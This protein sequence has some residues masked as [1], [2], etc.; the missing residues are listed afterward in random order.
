MRDPSHVKNFCA[1][2][3]VDHGKTTLCDYLI[4]SNG[5][6]SSGL[7]GDL[8]FMDNRA[9]E[10]E[11]HI[12]VKTS[13]ISLAYE[14]SIFNV[15]DSPGHF[16]FTSEVSIALRLC[17]SAFVLIDIVDGVTNQTEYLIRNAFLEGIFM[18]IVFSKIDLLYTVMKLSTRE[19]EELLVRHLAKCNAIMAELMAEEAKNGNDDISN[20]SLVDYFCPSKGNVLFTSSKWGFGFSVRDIAQMYHSKLNWSVQTLEKTLWGPYAFD[21][22]KQRIVKRKASNVTTPSMFEEFILGR[23][24]RIVEA[25][26][27]ANG[28]SG[29][30][31]D[32][33]HDLPCDIQ[34]QSSQISTLSLQ[35][36]LSK[37]SPL[38]SCL[39][40]TIHT[41]FPSAQA[42][43]CA[44]SQKLCNYN[45]SDI[46]D[47]L[48]TDQSDKKTK[49]ALEECDPSSALSIAFIAKVTETFLGAHKTKVAVCKI[50]SG[51]FRV[52]QSVTL[53]SDGK[54][55][56]SGTVD[57]IGLFQGN[58]L[59]SV[60]SI[61]AGNICALNGTF[62]DKVVKFGTLWGQPMHSEI[63]PIRILYPSVFRTVVRPVDLSDRVALGQ[64]LRELNALDLQL[65][66]TI[67]DNGDFVLGTA[68]VVHT[69]RCITDLKEIAQVSVEVSDP[70]IP[71]L[72]T[73]HN[74]PIPAVNTAQE[75]SED[76][77]S[78]DIQVY[79]QPVNTRRTHR[80][81]GT[82]DLT[83][84]FQSFETENREDLKLNI[85]HENFMQVNGKRE[86]LLLIPV[87][88]RKIAASPEWLD[89][90]TSTFHI[91]MKS[92]PLARL[93]VA[94]VC[95]ILR[96]ISRKSTGVS[97]FAQNSL[98]DEDRNVLFKSL[99]KALHQEM[100][101]KVSVLVE[102]CYSCEVSVKGDAYLGKIISLINERRGKIL[103]EEQT[104]HAANALNRFTILATVPVSESQKVIDSIHNV[105]NGHACCQFFSSGW[106]DIADYSVGKGDTNEDNMGQQSVQPK[107]L[108]NTSRALL[109]KMKSSKGLIPRIQ[110]PK[111]AEKQKFANKA[112]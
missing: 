103:S 67:E 57:Y 3:H 54:Q 30:L 78:Y 65:D 64:A 105:S 85:E 100:R 7:A 34:L 102:P 11:K 96:D 38:E 94:R 53:S 4:S 51:T 110:L 28:N 77:F 13:V 70:L 76:T 75:T 79:G 92:G 25:F 37:W 106:E 50:L 95:F 5:I 15:V 39:M 40:R 83:T 63:R 36:I 27:P 49:I 69:E 89:T 112:A 108:G 45:P 62:L 58:D 91:A 41:V 31:S 26:E 93:P 44:N 19:M 18:C 33:L 101:S 84:L 97:I 61:G 43:Q 80:T 68:G 107:Y 109:E 46:F 24:A 8:R 20:S 23:I 1:L 56:I 2:A 90:I 88:D 66:V 48:C 86:N 17:E 87:R 14:Q 16:D 71:L 10:Q 47:S 12:T 73:V 22:A 35:K 9:D 111:N 82:I 81:D 59:I 55:G 98:D 21:P 60:P 32:A 74:V 72:E 6:I 29:D 42:A 104:F 99:P 52:D